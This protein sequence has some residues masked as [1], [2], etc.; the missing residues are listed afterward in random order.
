M[1]DIYTRIK[2]LR[3]KL[4]LSQQELAEKVGYNDKTAISHIENGKIDIPQSKIIAFADA[5]KTTP[6][7]LIDGFDEESLFIEIQKMDEST[8]K[9]LLMKL[10]KYEA[11]YMK[12]VT[13]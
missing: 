8:R 10:L 5:L 2:Q 11:D 7:Y 13:K 9:D 6:S 3:E 12:K 4:G 1:E